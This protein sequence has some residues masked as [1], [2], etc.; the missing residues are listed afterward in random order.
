[1]SPIP[2]T[3]ETVMSSKSATHSKNASSAEGEKARHASISDGQKDDSP[4]GL[5]D[6]A[7]QVK[8]AASGVAAVA[9][10]K[11][12]HV[13][14]DMTD[15]LEHVLQ[16]RKAEVAERLHG[17]AAAVTRAGNEL[18]D[19]FPIGARY[20][21]S[22]AS[23]LDTLAEAIRE[24]DGR[25]LAVQAGEAVRRHAGVVAGVVGLLGFATVRLLMARSGQVT[26]SG[27][28]RNDSYET[29]HGSHNARSG[30]PE[31][32]EATNARAGSNIRSAD[33]DLNPAGTTKAVQEA[34]ERLDAT[35]EEPGSGDPGGISPAAPGFETTSDRSAQTSGAS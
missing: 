8:T 18:R 15:E 34:L 22:G 1:M 7:D 3:L 12:Q 14:S 33:D 25:A 31:R 13:V 23:K 9:S 19:E 11:A 26:G 2:D 6:V 17:L 27:S 32:S 21:T 35:D 20:V 10:D 4:S 24:Q 30:V 16:E 28:S 5:S 29:E